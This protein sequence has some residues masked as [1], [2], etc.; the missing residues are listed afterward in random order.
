MDV[1]LEHL[2]TFH[3]PDW[4]ITTDIIFCAVALLGISNVA[5]LEMVMHYYISTN[6][7][8]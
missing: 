3:P 2:A 8:L 1:L 4:W 7:L 6:Y 5:M